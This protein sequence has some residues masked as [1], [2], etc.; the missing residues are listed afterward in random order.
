MLKNRN[1]NKEKKERNGKQTFVF[2][3]FLYL[4]IALLS[5]WFFFFL[6]PEYAEF[7]NKSDTLDFFSS[8]LDKV[9]YLK[10]N[11]VEKMKA[12]LTVYF[13]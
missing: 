4:I 10:D 13:F 5:C 7:C 8:R 12:C 11:T 2:K 3:L 1:K 6:K 9:T